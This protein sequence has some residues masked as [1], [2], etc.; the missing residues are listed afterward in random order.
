MTY[1]FTVGKF[2]NRNFLNV[3][4]RKLDS[5]LCVERYKNQIKTIIKKPY[6][7]KKNASQQTSTMS[8]LLL[9]N[10]LL[11]CLHFRTCFSS[12]ILLNFFSSFIGIPQQMFDQ[13]M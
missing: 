11:P 7:Q 9:S 1:T 5:F 12:T 8:K 2:Y 6:S 13:R 10:F 4:D 3:A